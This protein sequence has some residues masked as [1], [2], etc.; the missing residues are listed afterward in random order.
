MYGS[1][2]TTKNY[3]GA[4]RQSP[5]ILWMLISIFLKNFC[6]FLENNIRKRDLGSY[7]LFL[8]DDDHAYSLSTLRKVVSVLMK[9]CIGVVPKNMIIVTNLL[10]PGKISCPKKS[11]SKR[12]NPEWA[13]PC[14]RF[15]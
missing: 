11:A 2:K 14:G 12:H 9:I 13:E 15:D 8:A 6:L 4:D 7:C 3:E 1:I 10:T 5:A